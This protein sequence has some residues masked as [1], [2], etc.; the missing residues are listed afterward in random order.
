VK[1][2]GVNQKGSETDFV[3]NQPRQSLRLHF[4]TQLSKSFVLKGRG[5]A[6]WYDKG[7][8]EAEEGFLAFAEGVYRRK[9]WQANM[10]L[11]YFETGGYN[12]R[13]Y[14]YESDVL[15]SFSIPAFFNQGFRYYLNGSVDVGSKLTCWFRF[16]Q[17]IFQNQSKIGSGLDE[18]NGNRRTD[19]RFQI[20]YR[21]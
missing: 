13:I 15:Y 10:R 21:F 12:S 18:I 19:V 11:Q 4:T 14:A 5:E 20:M 2:R 7:G 1:S 6:L 3:I 8:A 17:S 16:A 9:V